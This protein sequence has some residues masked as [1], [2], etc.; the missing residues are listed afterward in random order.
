MFRLT[1]AQI[2]NVAH[3]NFSLFCMSA[4]LYISDRRFE[5][6]RSVAHGNKEDRKEIEGC[7]IAHSIRL[8]MGFPKMSTLLV[9]FSYLHIWNF[10]NLAMF[11]SINGAIE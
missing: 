5:F 2:V 1:T 11:N 6:A 7:Y 3:G 4:K 10:P 9:K 8:L